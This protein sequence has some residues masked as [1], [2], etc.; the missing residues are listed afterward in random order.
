M[1]SKEVYKSRISKVISIILSMVF[2]VFIFQFIQ[3]SLDINLI[4]V[5]IPLALLLIAYKINKF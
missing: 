3:G 5:S 2:L 4:I 1:V